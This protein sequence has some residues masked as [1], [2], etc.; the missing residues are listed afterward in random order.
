[1]LAGV[2]YQDYIEALEMTSSGYKVVLARD[3]DELQI[4]PYNK[5]MIR[6]WN[7][8]MDLQPVLDF[9]AVVTYVADYYAKDEAGLMEL[10]KAATED[11]STKDVKD[12]MIINIIS[13]H[14]QNGQND[15]IVKGWFQFKMN[16]FSEFS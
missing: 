10:I 6:A 2:N 4:N 13:I 9:F 14:E 15:Q 11:S 12:K 8:N 3:I 7:G 5:E 1:M 16:F